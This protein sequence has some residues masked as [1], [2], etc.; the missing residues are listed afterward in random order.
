MSIPPNINEL[1]QENL[2][3]HI[4][5][6]TQNQNLLIS[7]LTA[8]RSKAEDPFLAFRTPDPIK[9][10]PSFN[11]NKRETQAWIKDT[12]NTLKLFKNYEHDPIYDQITRAIKA[13]IIGDAKEVLIAAGN[14]DDWDTIKGVLE[15]SYGDRRDLT[16]HIQSLFYIRQG[17]KSLVEYY[18]KIKAID[19]AIKAAAST[20]D[21]YMGSTKAINTLISLMTHKIHRRPW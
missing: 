16:S 17:N 7:Q 6:L 15:N 1:S 18:N 19:T 9:N 12:E 10:L 8:L 2:L 20:H 13:K 4:K 3:E 11:G 14:P 21:E 5:N